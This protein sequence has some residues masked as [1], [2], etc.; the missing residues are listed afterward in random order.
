MHDGRRYTLQ[1]TGYRDPDGTNVYAASSPTRYFQFKNNQLTWAD[2]AIV[3][4]PAS[5]CLDMDRTSYVQNT[6]TQSGSGPTRSRI[7]YPTSFK[8]EKLRYRQAGRTVPQDVNVIWILYHNPNAR[9]HIGWLKNG[10][11]GHNLGGEGNRPRLV[12]GRRGSG[13]VGG[14]P[15]R[16]GVITRRSFSSRSIWNGSAWHIPDTDNPDVFYYSLEGSGIPISNHYTV[17]ENGMTISKRVRGSPYT[18][19][20]KTPSGG[21]FDTLYAEFNFPDGYISAETPG[22]TG[23]NLYTSESPLIHIYEVVITK[24]LVELEDVEGDTAA[25]AIEFGWADPGNI[26]QEFTDTQLTR[27][28]K[29]RNPLKMRVAIKATYQTEKVVEQLK[30]LDRFGTY[31]CIPDPINTPDIAFRC[32]IPE[33]IQISFSNN[34]KP[35]LLI[36]GRVVVDRAP[37][38]E[39]VEH[40]KSPWTPRR[41]EQGT[42]IYFE[43]RGWQCSSSMNCTRPAPPNSQHWAERPVERIGGYNVN[44]VI[45]EL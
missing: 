12:E 42:Y 38:Y 21:I 39:E 14:G 28:R 35:A 20:Y 8:H 19:F 5:H 4:T 30:Q 6:D 23:F 27:S 43:N 26:A 16:D 36:D 9:N 33:P 25:A 29:A 17:E 41:F 22:I 2:P 37:G 7:Q 31:F 15:F 1:N 11:S 3:P 10:P 34:M 40:I 45:E 24:K 13:F 18:S 44:L 32:S